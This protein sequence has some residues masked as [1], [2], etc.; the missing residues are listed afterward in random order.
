MPLDA[1]IPDVHLCPG[2]LCQQPGA[3]YEECCIENV[4]LKT[5]P[6][7]APVSSPLDGG[8]PKEPS[9]KPTFYLERIS[10]YHQSTLISSL[11]RGLMAEGKLNA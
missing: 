2:D 7:S 10:T 3:G 9:Q 6:E 1:A 11:I 5:V 8:I 4:G